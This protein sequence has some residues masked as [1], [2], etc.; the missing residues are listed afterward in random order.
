MDDETC[1]RIF[2]PFYTTKFTGR[3]LGMA[4]IHG[5]VK[6]HAGYLFLTSTPGTGTTFKVYFPLPEDAAHNE[7]AP[8]PQASL[9]DE[10]AAGTI[11]VVE[12]EVMLRTLGEDLLV[13]MG[14]SCMTAANGLEALEIYRRHA[15]KIDLVLL[16]MIMPVMGGIETYH[17]LRSIDPNLPIIICSGYEIDSVAD[18]V[19]HDAHAAFIHKPYRPEQLR[20]LAVRAMQK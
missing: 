5:I 15:H 14:F 16:D 10:P 4:A 13:M 6:G 19:E 11:L 2:E 20:E 7:T 18:I 8:S 3:G 1:R 12:D 17:E 9:S